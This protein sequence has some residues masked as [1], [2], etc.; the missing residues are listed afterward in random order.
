MAGPTSHGLGGHSQTLLRREGCWGDGAGLLEE[1]G[2]AETERAVFR[3]GSYCGGREIVSPQGTGVQPGEPGRFRG[4]TQ[5]RP[6]HQCHRELHLKGDS[7]MERVKPTME[8]ILA[9][10]SLQSW[11][12]KGSFCCPAPG[13]EDEEDGACW[14]QGPAE[15]VAGAHL[16]SPPTQ[17]TQLL[18]R[19]RLGQ[20]PTAS[21]SL[22]AEK[23]AWGSLWCLRRQD[24][25]AKHLLPPV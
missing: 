14:Q 17:P 24:G 15:E 4:G 7:Q 8:R 2:E 22:L 3:G 16:S 10:K 6:T 5:V 21:Q 19:C 18:A 1:R 25:S 11:L 20:R 12:W 13:S 9:V 23:R